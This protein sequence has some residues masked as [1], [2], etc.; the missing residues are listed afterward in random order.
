MHNFGQSESH[1]VAIAY[2]NT[3]HHH[4]RLFKKNTFFSSKPIDWDEAIVKT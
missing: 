4:E 1:P 2:L 3:H